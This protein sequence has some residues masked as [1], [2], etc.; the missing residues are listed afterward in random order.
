MVSVRSM[1]CEACPYRRD[2]ASG[3][4]AAHE[5]EKLREYDEGTS[6]QP[7]ASFACHATPDHHCHGWAVVHSNRGH[8]YELLALRIWAPDGGIPEPG[9]PLFSSGNEAANHG[10]ADVD[11]PAPDA[12]S[13]IQRL[14][15]KHDR[16]RDGLIPE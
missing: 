7:M 9:V 10:Q 11:T 16:L 15:R 5:Y 12:V 4:W 8:E 3:V 1:P 2:V 13:T 14:L 6:Q